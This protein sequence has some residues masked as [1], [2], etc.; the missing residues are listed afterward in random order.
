MDYVIISAGGS[1]KKVIVGL[2]GGVDSSVSAYL[3]KKEGY[4]VIGVT[5][6]LLDDFDTN[7]ALEVAK[8]L[9]IEFHIE[10]LRSE[11]KNDIISNFISE[12]NRGMT[13]NPCVLCNQKIKFKY[14]YNSLKKY[15]A[16]YIAT[17]HYAKVIDG[18]LYRSDD[19]EKD[20]TYFL[21]GLNKE[22][23]EKLIFP[24][25]NL[26]KEEVR[27]IA[28]NEKLVT[29][30]KK[31]SYDVCFIK[32]DFKSFFKD[33]MINKQGSIIN[34]A[35]N[36]KLGIHNGLAYYTIGQRK[37]LDIGGSNDRLFVVGKDIKKNILYVATSSDND[38]LYSDS[39]LVENINFIIKERPVS[40][41]AK[42]RY[43]QTAIPVSLEY[44]DK[45]I[46]VHY[47]SAKAVTPGQACV[48]YLDDE[49]I[50]GGIIREV[51]KNDEKLWYLS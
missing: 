15:N 6:K 7:D 42:F 20:Q 40:C 29:A 3:L 25:E 33:N 30:L 5:Y 18:K 34:I 8:N 9:G 26:T 47:D 32:D 39:C 44:L 21:Y 13:P 43:R 36:E 50:G 14:L 11:F 1:M 22:I 17:G 12:Y 48:F 49:C 16:D 2:S 38:Y 41:F 35:T 45:S 46:I 31:D 28:L 4:E 19:K 51:R 37:G 27:T 10:D 23:I 24:L